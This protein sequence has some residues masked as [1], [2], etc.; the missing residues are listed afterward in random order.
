MVADTKVELEKI[1]KVIAKEEQEKVE[2]YRDV[3]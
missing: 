3:G 1:K 2:K